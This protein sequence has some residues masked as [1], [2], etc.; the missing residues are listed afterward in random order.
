MAARPV[1][2]SP[3]APEST[4]RPGQTLRL[5]CATGGRPA[6]VLRWFDG[7]TALEEGTG[8]RVTVRDGVLT[9]APFQVGGQRDPL[10]KTGA[11]SPGRGLLG[12]VSGS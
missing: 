11:I 12:T 6:P 2:S 8:G 3:S 9:V 5:Q 4:L 7:H 1:I 10:R